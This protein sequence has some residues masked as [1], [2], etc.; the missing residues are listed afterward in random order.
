MW[1]SMYDTFQTFE[2]QEEPTT[3]SEGP[4]ENVTIQT[5]QDDSKLVSKHALEQHC[6]K[7]YFF[8]RLTNV[9]LNFHLRIQF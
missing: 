1:D 6:G 9:S 7:C 4:T 2:Q 8:Q 3:N 5:E